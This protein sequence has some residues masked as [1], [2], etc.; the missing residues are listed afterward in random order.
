MKLK[1]FIS[2]SI[3]LLLTG[4]SVL[5][6]SGDLYSDSYG[7]TRSQQVDTVQTNK[8]TPQKHTTI[9]LAHAGNTVYNPGHYSN[10]RGHLS[11]VK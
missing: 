11:V 8:Q 10:E 9:K 5:S 2:V 3:V 6:Q 7:L 4:A 1:L